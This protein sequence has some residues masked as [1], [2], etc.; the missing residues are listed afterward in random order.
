MRTVVVSLSLL[1]FTACAQPIP[2]ELDSS[3]HPIGEVTL[4][5]PESREQLALESGNREA[6]GF[7]AHARGV[8][9]GS[10]QE[11]ANALEPAVVVNHRRVDEW[12]SRP[13]EP[14]NDYDRGFEIE[15]VV[16]AFVTVRFKLA[17]RLAE[18]QGQLFVRWS[19]SEGPGFLD[20][21]EGSIVFYEADQ[22]DLIMDAVYHLDAPSVTTET[23]EQTLRDLHHAIREAAT[24]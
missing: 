16:D 18:K 19:L 22:G 21:N 13:L 10:I 7:Y 9:P 23:L 15:N 20:T 17:W 4:D 6:G 2:R 11:L 12:R 3:M 14:S 24:D 5:L 1:L 8:V